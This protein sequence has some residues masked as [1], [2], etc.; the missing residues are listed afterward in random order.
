M[1]TNLGPNYSSPFRTATSRS[2]NQLS[3]PVFLPGSLSIVNKF[4][5]VP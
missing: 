3:H 2:A 4:F 1:T 5:S